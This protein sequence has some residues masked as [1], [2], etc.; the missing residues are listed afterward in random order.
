MYNLFY[1]TCIDNDR[2]YGDIAF[3]DACVAFTRRVQ[4][5]MGAVVVI[6]CSRVTSEEK[7]ESHV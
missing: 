5:E 6:L 1:A 7:L 2:R 4:V 3:Y